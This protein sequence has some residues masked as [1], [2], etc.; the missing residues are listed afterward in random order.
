MNHYDEKEIEGMSYNE[1]EQFLNIAKKMLERAKARKIKSKIALD[2]VQKLYETIESALQDDD[3]SY[4]WDQSPY[5]HA[6]LKTVGKKLGKCELKLSELHQ[7]ILYLLTTIEKTETERN[8]RLSVKHNDCRFLIQGE[9]D[10]I[11][12]ED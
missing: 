3:N 5:T 9:L 11:F 6:Y 8:I 4:L 1:L 12:G 7:E 10:D 2:Q